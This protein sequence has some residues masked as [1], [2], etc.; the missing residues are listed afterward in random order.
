MQRSPRATNQG[1]MRL[2][3]I[4]AGWAGMAAAVQGTL[5]GHHVSVFEASHSLGGRARS[6]DGQRADATPV[7][8]DNG[9]HILIGAYSESLRL[10]QL[11]GVDLPSALLRQTLTLRFPDGKGLQFPNWPAPLDALAGLLVARG[12]SLTDKWLALLEMTRW[13]RQGFTCHESLSVAQLCQ[14]LSPRV[15]T[16]LIEPLCLSALNRPPDQASASVFL[17]VLRDAVRGP[18]GSSHLLLPRVSLSELFPAPARRWLDA[19][20]CAI[21]L[22]SRVHKLSLSGSQWQVQ[23]RAFDR[24]ILATPARDAVKIVSLSTPNFPATRARS[25][26]AW[27]SL[28][29]DLQFDAI[30]TVYAW[31]S[32]ATL[33]HPMLALRSGTH[34]SAAGP[35]QFVFDRGQLGGPAGLLAFVVSASTLERKTLQTQVLEQARQQLGLE[36]QVVQTI[37]EKRATFAC[38]PALRRPGASVCDG[39]LACGDYVAGPYPATLE[40]AV[41]SATAAV[42]ALSAHDQGETVACSDAIARE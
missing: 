35:A 29:N 32:N 6:L 7:T 5:A 30:A 26:E 18:S 28:C 21:E 2:A 15:Q 13:Q 23:E 10:L 19:R 17:R 41:R 11:V 8:L 16:E 3:I 37:V 20:G 12:W 42:A 38:S 40:G 1:A 36:L 9:Q 14:R 34:G 4:G 31:A 25:S 39:L 24:V 33:T 22:G 27:L